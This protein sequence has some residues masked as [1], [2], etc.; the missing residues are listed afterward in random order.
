MLSIEIE[1]HRITCWVCG[2]LFYIRNQW[3]DILR[4]K[5][6]SFYC[7][8]GCKIRYGETDVE[9]LQKQILAADG[10]LTLSNRQLKRTKTLLKKCEK[11]R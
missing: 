6:T 5:G 8:R 9:K 11:K 3:D 7:P 4:K 1:M 2:E 10:R